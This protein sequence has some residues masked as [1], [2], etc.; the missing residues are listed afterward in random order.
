MADKT[1]LVPGGA[2]QVGREVARRASSH[3]FDAVAPGR[4]ALDIT[5]R[6]AIERMLGET[7][8]VAVINC[9][10]YTAVDKAE[11]ERES[12]M[13]VN[14][15]GPGHLAAACA[16]RAIPLL[17]ISTDYVFAGD[18]AGAYTEDDPVAPCNAYGESKLAGEEAI[19]AAGGSHVI[20]RTAWVYGLD[21]GNFLKTM[22]RLAGERDELGVVDDQ[23]GCPTFAGDIAEALLAMAARLTGGEGAATG[24]FH[25]VADG[26]V[27]WADFAAVIFEELEEASGKAVSLS[28]IGTA[29]FPTPAARPANSVLSTAKIQ[30]AYAIAPPH[31][32]DRVRMVTRQLL[33]AG[34]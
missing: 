32:E 15:E 11:S 12:A 18:K 6:D 31:W 25:Y 5:S 33:A 3:G 10:A 7:A 22:L 20:L 21:G 27:S 23:R 1:V 26:G 4:A 19:R 8:P 30:R 17:H 24:T 13:A 29:D 9:A 16:A 14:G 34:R 2:G 28:R